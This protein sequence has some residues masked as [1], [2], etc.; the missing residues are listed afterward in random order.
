MSKEGIPY[1]TPG[2]YRRRWEAARALMERE[3]TD[4]LLVFGHSGN[5]GHYQAH[6]HY[7]AHVAPRHECYLIFPLRGEPVLFTTHYNH[8]ASAREVS[9]VGDVR[10]SGRDAAGAVGA[11]LRKRGFSSVG[12]V[13]DV[14]YQAMDALRRDL[15]SMTWKDLTAPCR[16]L[17]SRKSE[18]E[19]DFQRRAAAGVDAAM[20]ALIRELRPGVTERDLLIATE[21]AAWDAGCEPVF[22]YLNSTPM[23]ASESC[24]PN[25][26]VSR[27]KIRM[28]DVINTELTVGYGMYAAQ[29]LRPF[30]L[31]EPTPAYARLYEVAKRVHD[32][33]AGVIRAGATAQQA[34][35]A[36]RL[37]EESGFTIVDGLLHGF[38]V[39]ILPP[40]I[41]CTLFA[42]PAPFTFERNMTVVV[43]PNPATKDEKM[44][45]QLGELGLVTERGFEPM[46]RLP[47]EAIRVA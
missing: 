45:V 39:D 6:V 4:A 24:V 7:L 28:G 47:P 17:R 23:A 13:G 36:T 32:E 14:F 2:E 16:L 12:V 8:L 33:V 11:E 3:G 9:V 42:P 38:G 25:Q 44:G 35:D 30:F 18:E 10:R 5:R 20:D 1:F 26:N 19:L 37:I 29:I 22:L 15:P 46:H 40:S 27:R 34:H 43:Q 41:R 31:G 21:K